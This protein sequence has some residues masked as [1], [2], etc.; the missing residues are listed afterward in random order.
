MSAPSAFADEELIKFL[1][2]PSPRVI[3]ARLRA[4]ALRE[5]T[6]GGALLFGIIFF[7]AGLGFTWVFFPVRQL[8]QWR[9]ERGPTSEVAGQ[10]LSVTDTR[11]SINDVR[12]WAYRFEFTGAEGRRMDGQCYTTGRRWSE[13]ASVQVVY[14]SSDPGLA[15]VKGAR[16]GETDLGSSFVVL[17]PVIGAFV[18]G[19]WVRARRRVL[20][21]LTH[22]QLGDFV[23]VSVEP[24]KV[25]IND[26]PQ[27]KITLKRVDAEDAATHTVRWHQPDR[28]SL[29]ESRKA[30]GQPIFGLF[31]P[32]K[33]G[34][35]VLPEIWMQP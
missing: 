4:T 1:A 22:G 29:I 15:C 33:P 17:F 8:D 13:G 31:D 32:S 7:I 19:W 35:I 11:L 2:A 9:L 25:R 10:V 18:V 16:L 5:T 30:S 34:R 27:F 28:L 21:L 20:W 23:V 26:Q 3:P 12:V 14:A 24:T 6:L